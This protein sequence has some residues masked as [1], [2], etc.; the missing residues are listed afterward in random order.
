[1]GDTPVDPGVLRKQVREKQ[2]FDVYAF[3]FLA[4]APR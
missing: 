2:T 4:R 3:P 1:M